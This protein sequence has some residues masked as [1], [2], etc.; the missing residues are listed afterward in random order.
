MKS[1]YVRAVIFFLLAIPTSFYIFFI[2]YAPIDNLKQEGKYFEV[3][4][5]VSQNNSAQRLATS[6]FLRHAL[7]L[8]LFEWM[9]GTSIYISEGT[10]YFSKGS[11]EYDIYRALQRGPTRL[12]KTIRIIEGWNVKQIAEYLD[13]QNFGHSSQFIAETKKDWKRS[14]SFLSGITQSS[15]LEG[16]L[17]P[18]TYRVYEDATAADI[19]QKMLIN[20]GA[21]YSDQM[22]HDTKKIGMTIHE[23]VTLASIIEKEVPEDAHRLM[24]SDIFHRRLKKG[25][26]LQADSTVNYVTG[27]NVLQ[28]SFGDIST[29][30]PYN[31]YAHSG[32]PLGPI[33]NPGLSS[34]QAALYPLPN[35]FWFFLTGKDGTVYYSE[36]FEQHKIKKQKYL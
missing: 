24:V 5:D 33:S 36:T 19:I 34:L 22:L 30:S 14:F 31:T 28:A 6:G 23:I 25:M 17:F 20:F 32:L 21:K 9:T 10:Y 13:K 4:Q 8:T 27:K 12:E 7:D 2:I 26:P 16:Y 15:G 11:S 3:R 1:T 35:K 18:D 29:E